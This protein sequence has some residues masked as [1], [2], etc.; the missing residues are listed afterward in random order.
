MVPPGSTVSPG[1]SKPEAI[2]HENGGV[3]PLA[4]SVCVYVAPTVDCGT[5]KVMICSKLARISS[6]RVAVEDVDELSVTRTVKLDGPTEVAVP[7]II[8]L[9]L[10][11]RPP[12]SEPFARDHM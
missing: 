6:D 10:R 5:V 11:L 4:D 9:E 2:D 8:P 3:P 7:Y 12:G 1:G